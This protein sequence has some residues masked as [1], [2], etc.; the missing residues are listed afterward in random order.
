MFKSNKVTLVMN[1]KILNPTNET[2]SYIRYFIEKI[3][4][5]EWITLDYK[6]SEFKNFHEIQSINY[7]N[8]TKEGILEKLN[9]IKNDISELK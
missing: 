7:T 2:L 8:N 6:L 4:K 3:N 9:T 5:F 1:F